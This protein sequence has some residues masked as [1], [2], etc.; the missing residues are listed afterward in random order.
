MADGT[1]AEDR[2]AEDGTTE[3]LNPEERI[4]TA[5]ADPVADD[6]ATDAD[7]D[8]GTAEAELTRYAVDS[9]NNHDCNA[10]SHAGA[11]DP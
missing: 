1:G 5:E 3:D 10:A 8:H 4:G 2:G 11:L 6:H 7:A 9:E